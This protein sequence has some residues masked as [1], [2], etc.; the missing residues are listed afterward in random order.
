M[1]APL[2]SICL[3]FVWPSVLLRK[4]C[5][6]KRSRM[7]DG[8]RERGD[9]NDDE[10]KLVRVL[11]TSLSL[12]LLPPPPPGHNQL[13]KMAAFT[14]PLARQ[15]VGAARSSAA[16]RAAMRS[17]AR[18]PPVVPAPWPRST[19][20]GPVCIPVR[21]HAD[22]L[23]P[24]LCSVT[25]SLIPRGFRTTALARKASK[26][27]EEQ[28]AQHPGKSGHDHLE[29]P[30]L[31]EEAVHADRAPVDPIQNVKVGGS[32][33][34]SDSAAAAASSAS[35]TAR[36]AVDEAKS[37]AQSAMDA[38][39]D[40]A[41]K[42]ADA[43]GAGSGQ[44]RSYSSSAVRRAEGGKPVEEQKA[45]HPEK[46][47]HEHMEKPSRAAEEVH[48]DR[49]SK[50]PLPDHKKASTKQE[51]GAST[52][53]VSGGTVDKDQLPDGEATRRSME[54]E[55]RPASVLRLSLRALVTVVVGAGHRLG[56]QPT[57]L[58]LFLFP[59]AGLK[60]PRPPSL[61]THPPRFAFPLV[62]VALER[63]RRPVAHKVYMHRKFCAS[64]SA[65]C[66][67]RE[68]RARAR[69]VDPVER[70]RELAAR[71]LS[72][73]RRLNLCDCFVPT[74]R[75]LCKRTESERAKRG[76]TQPSSPP[77]GRRG[78]RACSPRPAPRRPSRPARSV[79]PPP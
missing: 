5:L 8:A 25:P 67:C 44:K 10:R 19:R 41:G 38:V 54:R 55:S 72:R 17:V 70:V 52:N 12:S 60:Q 33:S 63:G 37:T 43:V 53:K 68:P 46:S 62:V 40:V 28:S 61:L 3:L 71:E 6:L 21:A 29:N 35:S 18:P 16:P 49:S 36:S 2:H 9:L 27:V 65:A 14:A 42:V 15:L 64:R 73:L 79:Q 26:P 69:A 77:S 75:L 59:H 34:V 1:I 11:P 48:A 66:A 20:P 45:Q 39:K 24:P 31:S 22:A 78:E 51:G 32:P 47:G 13:F 74:T 30:S 7:R 56:S 23:C 4:S 57:V 50:D 76:R 58:T